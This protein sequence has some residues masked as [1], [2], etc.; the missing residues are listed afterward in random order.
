MH[1]HNQQMGRELGLSIMPGPQY[2]AM[3]KVIP[4]LIVR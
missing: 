3:V 4:G 1:R 2:L